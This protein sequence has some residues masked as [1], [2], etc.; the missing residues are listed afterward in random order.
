MFLVFFKEKKNVFSLC[1]FP[2][3]RVNIFLNVALTTKI[4]SL[5]AQVVF[6][7]F[8]F[9]TTMRVKEKTSSS[10]ILYIWQIIFILSSMTGKKKR[11]AQNEVRI[12]T[13]IQVIKSPFKVTKQQQQKLEGICREKFPSLAAASYTSQSMMAR[14]TAFE[15]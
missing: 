13:Y 9:W 14:K 3:W 11:S 1:V 8:F 2:L 12:Y 5:F 7:L 10:N 4:I 6:W 15:Q